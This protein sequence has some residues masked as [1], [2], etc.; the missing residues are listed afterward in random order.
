MMAQPVTRRSHKSSRDGLKG[1]HVRSRVV[2]LVLA[3][4]L[5]YRAAG[6]CQ[7]ERYSK[8]VL[9]GYAYQIQSDV[10]NEMG[11]NQQ[12][13]IGNFGTLTRS[14]HLMQ[15]NSGC[16][17]KEIVKVSRSITS[18]HVSSNSK[19]GIRPSRPGKLVHC[20]TNLPR[21]APC[22]PAPCKQVMMATSGNSP[23][24]TQFARAHSTLLPFL[25]PPHLPPTFSTALHS[26]L[27]CSDDSLHVTHVANCLN[28]VS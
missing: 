21:P 28:R 12:R 22:S 10:A 9:F 4:V 5:G 14:K 26:P 2:S 23:F 24:V 11:P 27:Y 1:K 20:L 6:G 16:I 17:R 3:N 8:R 15:C 13:D 25:L 7:Q 18:S 19:A